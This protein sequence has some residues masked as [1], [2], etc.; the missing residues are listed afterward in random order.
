LHRVPSGVAEDRYSTYLQAVQ[1]AADV[2]GVEQRRDA[3]L[4]D[5]RKQDAFELYNGV[6]QELQIAVLALELGH[7]DQSRKALL[8]ASDNA[9]STLHRSL[10]ALQRDGVPFEQLLREGAPTAA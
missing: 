7:G 6:V 4:L 5:S 8:R 10:D 3:T 9:S 1:R 2:R